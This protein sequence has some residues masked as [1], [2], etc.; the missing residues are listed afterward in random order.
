[1]SNS[2]IFPWI[3]FVNNTGIEVVAFGLTGVFCFFSILL[4]VYLIYRHATHWIKPA[5]QNCI[6]RILLII[7]IYA[8]HS[9]LAVIFNKHALYFTIVRDC[10]EAY[11]LYQFF[12][13]LTYYI[14]IEAV[15]KR[16]IVYSLT[17]TPTTGDYL[18][19]MKEEDH[20]PF[21]LCCVPLKAD[22][23]LYR[24]TKRMVL[25][26][27]FVKPT[28][29]LISLLLY[30]IGMYDPGN[31]MPNQPY[32]W[33][34]LIMNVSVSVTLYGII[35]LWHVTDELISVYKPFMKLISI[36]ILIFFIFWQSVLLSA[37]YYFHFF[38]VFFDW[39]EQRSADTIENIMI[40]IEMT[41]L[42]LFHLWAFPYEEY[43]VE[44]ED[45]FK[46][47]SKSHT[48]TTTTTDLEEI[49]TYET[50]EDETGVELSVSG[51]GRRRRRRKGDRNNYFDSG[52]DLSSSSSG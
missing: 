43:E 16:E 10:Y 22:K 39:N 14:N 46:P 37:A 35:I 15:K 6:I 38:P 7:P 5:L 31:L 17:E 47:K 13:L 24:L 25:Q 42:S 4:T 51:R 40:C 36:K 50:I 41:L 19:F 26:Y 23:S 44:T 21:P 49:T 12:C 52:E 27:V 11:V 1:M 34:M 48:T 8:I 30:S 32:L 45:D 33:I 29:S 20:C 18:Q 28:L 3:V 2:T 9:W